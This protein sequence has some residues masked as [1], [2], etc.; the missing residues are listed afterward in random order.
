[1]SKRFYSQALLKELKG[2]MLTIMGHWVQSVC[3]R[4]EDRLEESWSGPNRDKDME[5]KLDVAV[6]R[7]T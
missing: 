4:H 7:M 1:M 6:D 5:P 2:Q 3:L